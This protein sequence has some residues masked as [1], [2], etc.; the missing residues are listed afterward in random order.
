MV[1]PGNQ[2]DRKPTINAT[3]GFNRKIGA[4]AACLVMPMSVKAGHH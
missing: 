1:F 3:R 4:A 2:V